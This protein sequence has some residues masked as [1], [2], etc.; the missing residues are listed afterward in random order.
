MSCASDR[1][2]YT[3]LLQTCSMYDYIYCW[4]CVEPGDLE[5]LMSWGRIKR[6]AKFTSTCMEMVDKGFG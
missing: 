6:P 5:A 3:I 2:M 4:R 1:Q